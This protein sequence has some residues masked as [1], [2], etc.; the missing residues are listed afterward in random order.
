MRDDHFAR[1]IGC[2][3]PGRMM[4]WGIRFS[5]AGASLQIAGDHKLVKVRPEMRSC[6]GRLAAVEVPIETPHTATG[7]PPTKVFNR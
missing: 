5:A 3:T 4:N 7:P 6:S 2:R 1:F